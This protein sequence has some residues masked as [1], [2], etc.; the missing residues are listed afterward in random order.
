MLR[1]HKAFKPHRY[2]VCGKILVITYIYT[3]LKNLMIINL[4]QRVHSSF[5]NCLNNFLHFTFLA[6]DYMLINIFMYL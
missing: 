4:S 6:H 2:C 5:L 1:V 3:S